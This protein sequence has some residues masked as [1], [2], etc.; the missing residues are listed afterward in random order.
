M[1][2]VDCRKQCD[3]LISGAAKGGKS[4]RPLSH[5]M[6]TLIVHVEE[7][8]KPPPRCAARIIEVAL[9]VIARREG[10]EEAA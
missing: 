9:A 6:P 5:P 2:A 7:G 10:K 4:S 1:S 3:E 8:W